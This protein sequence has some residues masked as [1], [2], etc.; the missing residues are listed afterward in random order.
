MRS[1]WS[2]SVNFGLVNIPVT[3]HPATK[4][5]SLSF[6]LLNKEDKHPVKY[7]KIDEAENT[8]LEKE[9]IVKGYEFE[10]GQFVVLEDKDF[11]AAEIKTGR[12]IDISDFVKIDQVDPIYF[13]KSYYLSPTK[14]SAKAYKILAEALEKEDR[15]GIAKVVMRNKQ[16]LA[17]IRP[18]EGMLV[19]ETMF[20]ND[21]IVLPAQLRSLVEDIEVSEKEL[22]MAEQLIQSMSADY[23][24]DKYT[25]QYR[26]NIQEIIDAKIRGREISV[27][28]IQPRAEVVDIMGALKESIEKVE[29]EKRAAEKRK[30]A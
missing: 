17:V 2:G 15:A 11:E 5:K 12:T 22:T 7:K 24:A 18:K 6:R 25:D 3:L 28:E 16:H 19:L 29:E 23:R 21:E 1:I 26:N 30:T 8:P 9:E 20:Y 14:T 13:Q 27:P 10:K 4:S